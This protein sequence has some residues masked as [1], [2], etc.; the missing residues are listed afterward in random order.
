MA[1]GRHAAENFT[2]SC[3]S[4]F[5]YMLWPTKT[6]VATQYQRTAAK[7]RDV[8]SYYIP[9]DNVRPMH[10]NFMTVK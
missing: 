2:A 3:R 5:L 10:N 9:C 4:R 8:K 7:I 6:G 1:A